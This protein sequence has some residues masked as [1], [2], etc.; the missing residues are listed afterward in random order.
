MAKTI[1]VGLVAAPGVSKNVAVHLQDELP[2][3]LAQHVSREVEW[4][5]EVIADPLTGSAENV[6]EIFKNISNYQQSY[7]WEYTIGLTDLP[8]FTNNK[9]IAIDVNHDNG[10]SLISVPAYGWRP[11]K[12]RL[13]RSIIGVIEEINK[14]QPNQHRTN[15]TEDQDQNQ[16]SKERLTQQ[17]PLSN[18]EPHT[19]Y[20]ENTNSKHTRYFVSSRAKG[21]IRLLSGMT[22]ANNPLNMV[23]SISNVLAVA[24]T[25]G[26]SGI[27]FTTMWNLSYLYSE[28]RLLVMMIVSILG[29]M[30]WIIIAH[31]LW[32]P[33][34]HSKDHRITRLYNFTTVTTLTVA[35]AFYYVLLFVFF[36][37][38]TLVVL[39]SGYLGQSMGLGGSA[40]IV[41]YINLAWFASSIS[42]VAAAIGA[43]LNN[44]ELILESTYGYRQKQRYK[45]LK[46]RE[47]EREKEE[48]NAEEKERS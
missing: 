39:P 44:A 14:Y 42:T 19:D 38:A 5:I 35:L 23:S 26:A 4:E 21:M 40:T 29:M 34:K 36:L 43:G 27:I 13:R 20:L 6:T 22:F 7:E 31:S 30:L 18:L 8:L 46:Q 28:L 24:F 16:S 37:L 12:K 33:I 2:D 9:V 10:A 48:E 15:Q 41:T 3:H 45:L 32:E 1:K 17:F 11:V 47:R 25:T